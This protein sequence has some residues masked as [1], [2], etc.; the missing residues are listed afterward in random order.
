MGST[1][2]ALLLPAL[3]IGFL[4]AVAAPLTAY[5]VVTPV[6]LA[7]GFALDRSGGSR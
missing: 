3:A 2:L 7:A 6:A 4:V 5:L 1:F